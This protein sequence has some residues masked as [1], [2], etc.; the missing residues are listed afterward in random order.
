MGNVRVLY[1]KFGSPFLKRHSLFG[2]EK[3]AKTHVNFSLDVLLSAGNS[4]GKFHLSLVK[5]SFFLSLYTARLSFEYY[6]QVYFVHS[7]LQDESIQVTNA[8][9]RHL[10]KWST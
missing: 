9:D 3:S 7:G 4:A 6:Q 1:R 5:T 2:A 8:R 10:K